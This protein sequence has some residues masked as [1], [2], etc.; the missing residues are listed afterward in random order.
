VTGP[1]FGAFTGSELWLADLAAAAGALEVIE[2]ITP[3]LSADDERKIAAIADETVRRER[4]AAHI[5]LRMLIERSFGPAWRRIA[6][7]LS[8]S[9]KPSLA[10]A[11]GAFSLSHAPGIALIGLS[12][13]GP[14]GVDIERMRRV[15]IS[16]DRRQRIEAAAEALA[17][18][19]PLPRA[20]AERL[21]SAWVRLEALAKA[22]GVGIG[23]LL[24]RLGVGPRWRDVRP[25]AA[26]QNLEIQ[27]H[28]V[29]IG[30]GIFAAVALAASE[31]APDLLE[32]PAT[33]AE[34]NSL[35]P[36]A[37]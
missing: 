18:R 35:L 19:A 4:R 26:S 32:L 14:I 12:T 29:A 31:A 30:A 8:P 34:L 23:P 17:S 33:E 1:A 36:D 3:R 21:M 27:V 2:A 24:T 20:P 5:A 37:P 11:P 25:G 7:A 16:D 6:Y 28:D 10:E 13:L 22:E 15:S 9:G